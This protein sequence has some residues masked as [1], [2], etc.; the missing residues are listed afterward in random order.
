M[1]PQARMVFNV[2][3]DFINKMLNNGMKNTHQ[4]MISGNNFH[5]SIYTNIY[6]SSGYFLLSKPQDRACTKLRTRVNMGED[7]AAHIRLVGEFRY[8]I[9]TNPLLSDILSSTMTK[10]LCLQDRCEQQNNEGE[11]FRQFAVQVGLDLKKKHAINKRTLL[12]EIAKF[13]TG[14]KAG[15]ATELAGRIL[16]MEPPRNVWSAMRIKTLITLE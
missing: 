5:N 3:M 16:E 6:H 10:D 13:P 15:P 14:L 12:A 4:K 11:N 7:D 2:V 9:I 1:L 8:L